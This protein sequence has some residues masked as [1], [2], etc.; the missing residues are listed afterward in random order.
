MPRSRTANSGPAYVSIDHLQTEARNPASAN[1]DE[2]TS[3]E[4]VR[5]MNRRTRKVAAAVGTQAEAI[6][7]A[8]DVI[9]E[10]L[11][12]R[13]AVGLRR[14]GNVG[15]ARRT[16]RDRMPA[17]VQLAARPG[18]RPHR[19]RPARADA[20]GRRGRGSSGIRRVRPQ[21]I[22]LQAER[23]GR[24]HRDERADAV[25]ARGGR[26]RGTSVGAF[27]IGLACNSRSELGAAS[28][29]AIDDPWSARRC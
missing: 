5:L 20:G 2:L 25:C 10:R 15:P 13:R 11:G 17:D 19:R 22:E 27:T 12:G 3:L 14:G 23:R 7:Q 26:I 16:R 4:I 1:L 8:I 21:A 6:A 9:A 28:R 24:R 18:G 29:F